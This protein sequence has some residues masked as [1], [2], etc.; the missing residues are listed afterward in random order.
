MSWPVTQP[1]GPQ[2]RAWTT[3]RALKSLHRF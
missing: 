2:W 3:S 1:R